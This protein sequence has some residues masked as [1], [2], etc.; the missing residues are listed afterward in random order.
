MEPSK[1]PLARAQMLDL[2][3]ITEIELLLADD[4]RVWIN[5]DGVCLVRGRSV[6][7]VR[8]KNQ[9]VDALMKSVHGKALA[10]AQEAVAITAKEFVV[11]TAMITDLRKAVSDWE[12]ASEALI[13]AER[14]Q[15]A[16]K[17]RF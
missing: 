14:D 3:K 2:D 16:G 8:V 13:Q 7:S 15:G 1:S 17:P 4:G 11:G 10:D 5:V 6:A 9:G 12:K